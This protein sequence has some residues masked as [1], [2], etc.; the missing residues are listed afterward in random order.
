MV[1][2]IRLWWYNTN[3]EMIGNGGKFNQT[4]TNSFI[5]F[6]K[7]LPHYFY[8]V[9]TMVLILTSKFQTFLT[10]L[11]PF[12]HTSV[13]HRPRVQQKFYH[14]IINSGHAFTTLLV[15]RST[16]L[17]R[18]YQNSTTLMSSF[19]HAFT[20]LPRQW[21]TSTMHSP[22]FY[23]DNG[24]HLP[25]IHPVS[26]MTMANIYHAFTPFLPWQWSTSTM[27]SPRFYHDN[28]Q[29]LPRITPFL[30]WEWLTSTTHSPR[31]YH[32]NSQHLPRIHPVYTMTMANLYH[33]FTPFLPWQWPTSTMH[34]PR[35][36]H[37]NGHLL[38][39][40]HPVSTMTMANIYHAFP[41]FLPWQ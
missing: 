35:F 41:L 9:F 27:H 24:Q 15:R 28:S 4:N 19:Y 7:F 3:L 30:P 16:F 22:R 5:T 13:K 39:R 38:P 14:T 18:I 2:C 8:H 20:I 29:L 6:T 37:D 31:F 21:P 40:I 23:H 1:D 26:T 17:S 36:Y 12:Y 34:S 33:T 25:C 11:S 10:H 32:D